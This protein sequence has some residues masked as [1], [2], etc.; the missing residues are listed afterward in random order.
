MGRAHTCLTALV[1][2]QVVTWVTSEGGRPRAALSVWRGSAQLLIRETV[3]LSCSV[4]GNSSRYWTFRWYRNG[5]PLRHFASSD[6]RYTV[7]PV[8]LSAS[9]RY[10]CQGEDGGQRTWL[11]PPISVDVVAGWAVLQLPPQP[12]LVG[13]NV[14]LTC[15][16]WA[17]PTLFKVTFYKDGQELQRDRDPKLLLSHVTQEDQGV[18]WC[19][20]TW[21]HQSQWHSVQSV[22]TEVQVME[23]LT[24]PLLAVVSVAPV[25]QGQ[26]LVLECQTQLNIYEDGLQM[27]YLYYR[28]GR[29]LGLATSQSRYTVHY[30]R[31]QDAGQYQC[32]VTVGGLALTKWSNRVHV[33][34]INV[35]KKA[36]QKPDLK[37]Q[38]RKG[39]S[40]QT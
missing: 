29:R 21:W 4:P 30:V 5:F 19:R 33:N 35:S 37:A 28:D 14:T 1:I 24:K 7:A 2:L 40:H 39:W 17:N 16:V 25:L 36:D 26:T 31:P 38:S 34:V 9:G 32:K 10:T 3:T 13:D 6:E 27:R 15:H 23:I 12:I 11:S 20:A 22:A 18:Y 8:N